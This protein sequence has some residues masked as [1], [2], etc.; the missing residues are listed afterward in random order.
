VGWILESTNKG[1]SKYPGVIERQF[2]DGKV[3]VYAF[4]L[5]LSTVN[6]IAFSDLLG[7]S[8]NHVHRPVISNTFMPGR[9]VP[10]EITLRSLGGAFDL[11]VTE[12]YPAGLKIYDPVTSVWITDDPWIIS[13]HLD[14]G[15]TKKVL[16]YVQTPDVT[17]TY[18][19][20][21]EVGYMDGGKYVLYKTLDA[22]IVVGKDTITV[23]GDVLG[24]LKALSVAG[25]DKAKVDNA[26]KYVQD[27]QARP[28]TTAIDVDMNIADL[29]KAVDS[30][31]FVTGTDISNIRHMLD[32][33]IEIWEGK[34]YAGR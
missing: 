26:I 12:T 1:T 5:G 23:T 18:I 10:V 14:P 2:G 21:T 17:G 33:L 24:A 9:M 7:K 19:T 8:L 15:E 29:L 3:I 25:Q 4:D 13:I 27:V 30:L 32:S 11:K 6:Y 16:Y 20:G 22:A 34:A 31:L 28:V